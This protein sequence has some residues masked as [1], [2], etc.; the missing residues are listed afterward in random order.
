LAIEVLAGHSS[1]ATVAV[2]QARRNVSHH[3]TEMPSGT[4]QQRKERNRATM[5]YES[6]SIE[7]IPM[8]RCDLV[9][10]E[11]CPHHRPNFKILFLSRRL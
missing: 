9:I 11:D 4:S 10:Y 7:E 8:Q 6:G 2:L 1:A 5:R 3:A